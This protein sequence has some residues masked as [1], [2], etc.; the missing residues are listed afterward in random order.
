MLNR[1]DEQL[2]LSST[3]SDYFASKVNLALPHQ[4]KMSEN[5]IH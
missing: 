2:F 4:T 3:P 5:E 1:D